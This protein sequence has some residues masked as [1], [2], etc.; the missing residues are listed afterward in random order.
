MDNKGQQI[1][2]SLSVIRVVYTNIQHSL[3]AQERLHTAFITTLSLYLYPQHDLFC[4]SQSHC[5]LPTIS[6]L[7]PLLC[8]PVPGLQ[9]RL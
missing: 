1:K 3:P 5:S 9:S 8:D 7:S 4:N 6:G 2:E